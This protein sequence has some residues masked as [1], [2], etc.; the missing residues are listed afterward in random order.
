VLFLV[1]AL[2]LLVLSRRVK[3]YEVVK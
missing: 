3:A 2:C 1:C